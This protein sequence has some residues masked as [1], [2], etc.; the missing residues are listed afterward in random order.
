MLILF[1]FLTEPLFE[2]MIR[3][4]EDTPLDRSSFLSYPYDA[5]FADGY[6]FI[7]DEDQSILRFQGS[8]FVDRIGRIGQAGNEF[9]HQPVHL[10]IT[11]NR[12]IAYERYDRARLF[13]DLAGRFLEREEI[14]RR[15]VFTRDGQ[16]YELLHYREAFA[17][18][19][20]FSSTDGERRFGRLTERDGKGYHRDQA[21]LLELDQDR[22][23]VLKR[24]GR[25]EIYQ[26]SGRLLRSFDLPLDRFSM[27]VV[28]DEIGTLLHRRAYGDRIKQYRYGLPIID[29]SLESPD[30]L[31]LI[32]R[33]EHH[34][35][36][37]FRP[38]RT[39]LFRIAIDTGS[40]S[41]ESES[42]VP[43][44]AIHFYDRALCV[45]SQEHASVWVFPH[46]AIARAL[47][48]D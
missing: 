32:V 17:Q 3:V 38:K 6:L 26:K 22:L 37:T 14:E 42:S 15:H 4:D 33:D 45:V 28:E 25:C 9:R 21:F 20:L 31:W 47:R 8:R 7:A 36:E 40:V 13:F 10:A 29:A 24:R 46:D 2:P 27:D 34:L 41:Y 30:H 48:S 39:H 35:D 18:G 44:T 43:I 5:I 16:R 1:L 11:G 19:F 12:L 23:L